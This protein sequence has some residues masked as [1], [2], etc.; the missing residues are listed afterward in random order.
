M[1]NAPPTKDV[2]EF[3]TTIGLGSVDERSKFLKLASPGKLESDDSDCW[4]L[5]VPGISSSGADD[6]ELE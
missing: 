3:F 6:A 2:L 4:V 1:E 5:N